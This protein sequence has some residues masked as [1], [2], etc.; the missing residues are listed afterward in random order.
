M[1]NSTEKKDER[2][3][4][5]LDLGNVNVDDLLDGASGSFGDDDDDE[6][7]DAQ[8]N[9]DAQE[10]EEPKEDTPEEDK[11]VPGKKSKKDEPEQEQEDEAPSDDEQEEPLG[12]IKELSGL[13]GYD[14][15][16]EF[17]ESIEG[18]AEYT[19]KAGEAI[20]AQKVNELFQRFPDAYE[21]MKHLA[22]GGKKEDYL[23][24]EGAPAYLDSDLSSA[25]DETLKTVIK[26]ALTSQ[27]FEQDAIEETLEDYEDTGLLKKQ[28]AIAQK[29]LKRNYE[30]EKAAR[31]AATQ[32][33]IQDQQAKAEQA[34]SEIKGVINKGELAGNF[35][36][37]EAEKPAFEKWMFGANKEGKT[38]RDIERESMSMQDKLAL[39][40]LFFKKFELGDMVSKK[41]K[42]L[43][44]QKLKE[45]LSK[46]KTNKLGVTRTDK[47]I[48]KSIP[49]IPDFNA[50]FGQ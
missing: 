4:N 46:Q 9:L 48:G 12:I 8:D 26:Q 2:K 20:A 7:S 32:K 27:G 41:A 24:S 35:R 15:E 30:K 6:D 10:E 28:A 40:Y 33:N 17:D 14:I 3:T 31:D 39:E 18:I 44:A 36:I 25:G 49:D 21:Y 23:G 45:Q 47:S 11:K 38:Q 16:G 19:K 29:Y 5:A 42:S 37:P 22:Q 13:L 1:E 43:T 34:V 50:L